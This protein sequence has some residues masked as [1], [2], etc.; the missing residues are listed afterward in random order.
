ME[1]EVCS[2]CTVGTPYKGKGLSARANR[3][4][5]CFFM[6]K[7][8][9]Y[10]KSKTADL[11]GSAQKSPDV[12]ALCAHRTGNRCPTLGLLVP[13][14]WSVNAQRLVPECPFDGQDRPLDG[15]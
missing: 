6:K 13:N 10:L 2:T 9:K 14:A 11:T 1:V 15:L 5:K 4:G 7:V 12:W 3:I 8:S